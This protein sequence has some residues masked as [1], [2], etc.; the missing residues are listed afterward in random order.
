MF[1]HSLILAAGR[2]VRLKPFT[3]KKPKAL[4]P[5]QNTTLINQSIKRINKYIQNIHVTVGYKGNILAKY[6]I[7][8]KIA[9]IIN[10][11]NQENSWWI[12]NSL[13]KNLDEPLLVLTCDNIT[14]INFST[15]FKEFKK[16]NRACMI[17]PA[18]PVVGLD[19]DYI[20]SKKNFVKKLSRTKNSPIYASGIQVMNPFKINKIIKKQKNN[21]NEV[22]KIL[23]KKKELVVS[24]YKPK[25]WYT[26]DSLSNLKDFKKKK[27]F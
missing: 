8:K 20:F 14:K 24:N 4:L 22:W 26:I 27:L 18:K 21:F 25:K 19:G 13:L 3:N 6:L 1:K 23:I 7:D 10:T 9:S 17:V 15:V 11:K 5:I 12:F 16:Y 2:G